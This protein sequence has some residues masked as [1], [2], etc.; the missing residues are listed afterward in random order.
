MTEGDV[1]FGA[2]S[3]RNAVATPKDDVLIGDDRD[4]VF[5]GFD[6]ADKID[7]KEGSD[8]VSYLNAPR[9]VEV[10]LELGKGFTGHAKGDTFANVEN[11]I[12]SEHNDI[13]ISGKQGGTING[14]G[15][16]NIIATAG[17]NDEIICG[18]GADSIQ[19]HPAQKVVSVHDF[20]PA[21][22]KVAILGATSYNDIEIKPYGKEGTLVSVPKSGTKVIFLGIDPS[23]FDKSNVDI[24][25]KSEEGGENQ[26]PST[27][28]LIK[29]TCYFAPPAG[30]KKKD[31]K[32]EA[33]SDDGCQVCTDDDKCLACEDDFYVD[34][35]KGCEPCDKSCA[36]CSGPSKGEC[37]VCKGDDTMIEG[38]CVKKIRKCDDP[39]H[40]DVLNDTCVADFTKCP[41]G[42]WGVK[43]EKYGNICARDRDGSK[44]AQ[45][46]AEQ[47][48]SRLAK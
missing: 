48:K 37:T 1:L 14:R 22:D 28:T 13:L 3:A 4:N 16:D 43:N 36:R 38:V 32:I 34:T 27:G 31:G 19:V 20:D 40:W 25:D 15:G 33:C 7:G 11:I 12:G 44:R 26:C 41:D 18:A 47:E 21:S 45:Y 30:H 46:E 6:G 29:G 10:S 24:F 35:K 39:E 8:T 17:G 2:N 23:K 9:G 42:Y 5:E